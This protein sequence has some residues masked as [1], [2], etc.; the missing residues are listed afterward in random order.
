MSE[1]KR[2]GAWP[3]CCIVFVFCPNTPAGIAPA[4]AAIGALLTAAPKIPAVALTEACVLKPAGADDPN[5]DCE[6]NAGAAPKPPAAVAGLC[7][8]CE[9]IPPAAEPPVPKSEGAVAAPLV[10]TPKSDG[11]DG[12]DEV[13]GAAPKREADGLSRVPAAVEANIPP[14]ATGTVGAALDCA[15]VD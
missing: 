4:P 12:A 1:A 11:A 8:C 6:P 13:A 10:A 2:F 5:A 7:C 15:K 9:N 14:P 3:A